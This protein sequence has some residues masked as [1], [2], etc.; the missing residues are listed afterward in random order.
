MLRDVSDVRADIADESDVAPA[1][2]SQF[3]L[4]FTETNT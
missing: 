3:E 2:P 4:N 1:S